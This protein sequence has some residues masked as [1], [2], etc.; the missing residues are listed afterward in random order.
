[1]FVSVQILWG[2][3]FGSEFMIFLAP[4]QGVHIEITCQVLFVS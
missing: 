2:E 4:I 3:Q 1:M